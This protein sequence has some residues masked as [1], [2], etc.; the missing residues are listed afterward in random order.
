[1][2][3]TSCFVDDFW[4]EKNNKNFVIYE[5]FCSTNKATNE[6]YLSFM[7]AIKYESII[8]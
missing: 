3:V 6:L 1:M 7:Y 8:H 5:V 2:V 4:F